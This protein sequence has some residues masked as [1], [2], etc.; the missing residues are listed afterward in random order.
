MK[1]MTQRGQSM[2]EYAVLFAIVL[3]AVVGLQGFLRA[4][5]RGEIE[6][7]A[8]LEPTV[9]EQA[10]ITQGK[11]DSDSRT[12]QNLTNVNA[13]LVEVDTRSNQTY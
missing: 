10:S 4:R 5:L 7:A 9:F 3:G 2:G 6:Q 1:L 12:R 11:S 8:A 13:G